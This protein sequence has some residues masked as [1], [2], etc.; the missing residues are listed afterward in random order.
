MAEIRET[1]V[2]RDENGRVTDTKVIIDHPKKKSGFGFGLL[3]GVVLIAGALLAFVYSQGSFQEAAREADQVAAQ[4]EQ[5]TAS[6]AD[7]AGDTAD[8]TGDTT[9]ETVTN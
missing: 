7:T 3:L 5:Q 8:R 1:H 2:K 9:S 6:V 4:V